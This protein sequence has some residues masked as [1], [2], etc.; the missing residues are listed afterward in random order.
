M[1]NKKEVER[2]T[3]D[4][5][6]EPG[7]PWHCTAKDAKTTPKPALSSALGGPPVTDWV[8]GCWLLAGCAHARH[9]L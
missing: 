5:A 1:T 4:V 6:A 3:G 7:E 9:L 8:V 2:G